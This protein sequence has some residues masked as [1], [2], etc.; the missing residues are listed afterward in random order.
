MRERAPARRPVA[1]DFAARLTGRRI[2]GMRP[3]RQVLLAPLDDGRRL[4][5]PPRHD[6]PLD[7]RPR[8]P[9]RPCA[10][11]HVVVGLDDGRLLTYNDPR[12]FGRMAVIDADAVAAETVRRR[13]R[14]VRRR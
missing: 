4:A 7:P 9:P 10:H 3:A 1:P 5:R 2:D 11:D 12:R 14:A 13:R 8:G 6:G